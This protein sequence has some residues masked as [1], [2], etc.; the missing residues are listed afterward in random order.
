MG[1]LNFLITLNADCAIV[2]DPL[3][4]VSFMLNMLMMGHKM[5]QVFAYGTLHQEKEALL[6]E[7]EKEITGD[8]AHVLKVKTFL[9]KGKEDASSSG[10]PSPKRRR[11]I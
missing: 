11:I 2:K 8:M 5:L 1:V 3:F 6:V 10:T 7:M 9:K 4:N